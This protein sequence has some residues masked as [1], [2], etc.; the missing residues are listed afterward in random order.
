[1][2]CPRCV[3]DLELRAGGCSGCGFSISEL[4][5]ELGRES[6]VLDRLADDAHVLR[7]HERRRLEWEL[8]RFEQLFPQLFAAIFI[9]V[10]PP[11]TNIRQFG[12][13]LL[14]RAAVNGVDVARPNERGMLFVLDLNG[15]Q[16]GVT[17]GY[18]LETFLAEKEIAK[19]FRVAKPDFLEGDYTTAMVKLL[20]RVTRR[21]KK[22][23]KQAARYPDRFCRGRVCVPA[24]PELVRVNAGVASDSGGVFAIGDAVRSAVGKRVEME[25]FREG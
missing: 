12:F 24:M 14:N 11:M 20:G 17:L 16:L 7:V 5:D 13:W 9:G 3:Q 21:L 23:S 15:K 4:D 19:C 25:R 18:Q 6:V 1:M 22:R 10:F 2:K 8:D